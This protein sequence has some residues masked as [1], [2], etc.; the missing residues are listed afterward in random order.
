LA[1]HGPVWV[2]GMGVLAIVGVLVAGW[3]RRGIPLPPATAGIGYQAGWPSTQDGAR[4]AGI[5]STAGV[6]IGWGV[7][8]LTLISISHQSGMGDVGAGIAFYSLI[9]GGSIAAVASALGVILSAITVRRYRHVMPARIGL[10]LSGLTLYII[11]MF[12]L[13]MFT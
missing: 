3:W 2:L 11:A 8:V 13:R 9:L 10:A 6:L 4:K 5:I 7:I 1:H 12:A